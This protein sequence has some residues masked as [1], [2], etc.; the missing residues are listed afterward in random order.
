MP[1][2]EWVVENWPGSATILAVRCKG[3]REG[4]PV[5]ET[6]YYVTSLRTTAKALLQQ[7]NAQHRCQRIGR[8]AAF[9]AR[10]GV[11]RLGQID[12]CLPRHHSL[13]LGEK[14]LA[15][16]ALLGRGQLIVRA[17]ELLAAHQPSLGVRLQVHFRAD[18]LGFPE[19][20]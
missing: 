2:P 7:M 12:E 18:G 14:L 17:T 8:P 3:I 19:L 20:P 9:L 11:V 13:H 1:A 10:L 4:K 6:R 16:G 15:L 5:D